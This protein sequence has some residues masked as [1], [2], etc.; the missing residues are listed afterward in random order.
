M[1]MKGNPVITERLNAL[2]GD[3]LAAINQY[4]V[5]AEMCE[6]WGYI[7][8]AKQVKTRA[9]GEMKHAEKLIE[10]I[11][12]LE[13][14]PVVGLVSGV[15][16]GAD[17]EKQFANDREAEAQAVKLYNDSIKLC[18]ELGDTGTRQLLEEILHDEETHLDW[19]ETQLGQI[20]QLKIENYLALQSMQE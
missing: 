17:I 4:I 16:I 2:L 20:S 3:E 8:L 9:I 19:L 1:H 15:S 5:H 10:R 6:N 13:E 7:R 11:L 12:F 14:A 18:A